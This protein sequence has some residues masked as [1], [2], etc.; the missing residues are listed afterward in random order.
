MTSTNSVPAVSL[1]NVS[2]YIKGK[3]ILN[4]ISLTIPP[5]H[6]FGI[7]GPNGAG[8]SMLLRI[9]SGLVLASKG[10][11]SIFGRELGKDM[12]FSNETGA[13]IEKP[14]FLTQYSGIQNLEILASIR[15]KISKGDIV[16]SL[17][18]VGLNPDDKRP[19]RTYS[20]GMLQRLGI[21]QAIMEKPKLLL[22]DEPTSSLDHQ[23]TK[24]IHLILKDLRTNGTTILLTSHIS[25]ELGELCDGVYWMEK[26]NL[27]GENRDAMNDSYSKIT[28]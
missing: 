6:I 13:V 28:V 24:D 5:A 10:K 19:V 11:V 1:R 17:R 3:M 7:S 16:A 12:E 26:G 25:D 22:L 8:K 9:I 14:G 23:G 2:K 15:N 27:I 21:A 20:T 18:N 4:N